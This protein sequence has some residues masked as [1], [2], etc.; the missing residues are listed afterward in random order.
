MVLIRHTQLCVFVSGD[1]KNEHKCYEHE[2]RQ[3]R[4]YFI[5][6]AQNGKLEPGLP[7]EPYL[8]CVVV[9]RVLSREAPS[10][11]T[12]PDPCLVGGKDRLQT[13]AAQREINQFSS[14]QHLRHHSDKSIYFSMMESLKPQTGHRETQ[15][16]P[17]KNIAK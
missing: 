9:N 15:S 14:E 4:S 6:S 10:S 11:H 2:Q 3:M 8:Q 1:G 16:S 5:S 7:S 12:P 17:I 13:Q